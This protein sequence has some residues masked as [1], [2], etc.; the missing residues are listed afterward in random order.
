[1]EKKYKLTDETIKIGEKILYRIEAL[2]NFSNLKKGDKGGFIEHERNLSQ[3]CNCWIYGNAKVYDNA[4]VFDDAEVFDC[5]KI[6]GNAEVYDNAKIYGNAVVCDNAVVC[7]NAKIYDNV[8]VCD[9]AEVYGDAIIT[10]NSDYIVFK[11]WWSSGRY[12]TWTRS[13][14]MWYVG[15]FYGTG[16]ELIEK[17]YKDSKLSGDEYKRIVDYVNSINNCPGN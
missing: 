15:C 12:F 2:E 7:V 3:Y 11:N 1:M 4:H 14:N 16:E 6:F 9:N 13:N 5:A 8:K 17:A 10:R